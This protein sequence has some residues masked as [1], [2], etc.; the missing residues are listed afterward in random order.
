MIHLTL[1][2]QGSGKTLYAV[3]QAYKA[4]KEGKTIYSNVKLNFPYKTLNYNDIINCNY[5]N[6][7]LI[8]DEIHQLLP[9][10]NSLSK[11]SRKICDSF[12]SMVRKKGTVVPLSQQEK[13]SEWCVANTACSERNTSS[14]CMT[15]ASAEVRATFC[16]VTQ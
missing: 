15:L 10:R 16:R 12:L 7:V 3:A 13:K 2:N 4:Y 14:Q 1:G 5:S 6:A 8:I 11:S 9:A